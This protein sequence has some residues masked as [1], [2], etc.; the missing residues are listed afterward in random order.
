MAD[1]EQRER[2]RAM[3][4]VFVVC[5]HTKGGFHTWTL[6][7][8]CRMNLQRMERGECMDDEWRPVGCAGSM[9]EALELERKLKAS[10]KAR[11]MGLVPTVAYGDEERKKDESEN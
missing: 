11:R 6:E 4:E 3:N 10:V 9:Q 7:Q 8:V 2:R 5:R 1:S